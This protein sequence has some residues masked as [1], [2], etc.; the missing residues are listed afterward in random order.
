MRDE[1]LLAFK[2][3]PFRVTA[4]VVSDGAV[5]TPDLVKRDFTGERPGVKFV[6]HITHLY[7]RQRFVYL[8]TVIDWSSKKVVGWSIASHMRSEL[9]ADALTNA[10]AT[11]VIEADALFH[12][13]G[14]VSTRQPNTAPWSHAWVSAHRWTEQAYVGITLWL[15][16][17]FPR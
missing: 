17:S 6:G 15:S 3:S 4:Q 5:V 1:G 16:R 9:A 13:D 14:A 2:P 11:T 8:G 7:T 12:S 10:A